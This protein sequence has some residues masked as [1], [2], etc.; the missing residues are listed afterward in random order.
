LYQNKCKYC[1]CFFD[2]ISKYAYICQECDSNGLTKKD[3][4]NFRE[5]AKRIKIR[6]KYNA[7][8]RYILKDKTK[9]EG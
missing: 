7:I 4:F 2:D 3:Q 5:V 8:S 6:L 1:E 9:E